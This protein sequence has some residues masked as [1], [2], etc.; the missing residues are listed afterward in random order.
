[1]TG[2]A[3]KPK[4]T[5]VVLPSWV[6]DAVM[7]TPALGLLRGAMPGAFLGGLARPGV[8]TV[9]EGGGML[10]EMHRAP[11]SGLMAPK[12]AAQR[13]RTRRYDAALLLTNSFST[14]LSARLAGIPIRVGY[15]RDGRG[16]L[17]THRLA[18][19]KRRETPPYARSAT[20]PGAWAPVPACD[21]YL[22]LT[23]EFLRIAGAPADGRAPPMRL[24][25]T[26]ADERAA[27]EIFRRAGVS[28]DSGAEPRPFIVLNPGGNNPAKRWPVDRFARLAS[29][30]AAGVLPGPGLDAPM[31]ILVSG[32]PGEAEITGEIVRRAASPL[33]VDL[34]GL[35]VGLGSLRAILRRASALVTNDTGPRHIAAAFGTPVISLFGP[36]DHRWTTITDHCPPR[37][38]G[39]SAPLETILVA[40]ASLPEEEVADDHPER[41]AIERIGY[42]AVA[43]ALA[44]A[45]AAHRAPISPGAA[46]EG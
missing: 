3:D 19:T 17:L 28:D 11:P 24:A 8:D 7:A 16:A 1:M 35:G 40:D 27:A 32:S 33:V 15:D 44:K 23:R 13:V 45:L 38:D 18:P 31:R 2:R 26:E 12:V 14:A 42:D 34:V 36:T 21:Y 22:R 6:G 46:R 10:D 5:L 41:C 39:A 4:R 30:L 43:H 25:T 20:D 37:R 9:L 29:A